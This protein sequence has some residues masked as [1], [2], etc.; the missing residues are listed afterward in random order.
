M[1]EKHES[2]SLEPDISPFFNLAANTCEGISEL[3]SSLQGYIEEVADDLVAASDEW[4]TSDNSDDSEGYGTDESSEPSNWDEPEGYNSDTLTTCAVDGWDATC[5]EDCD[6]TLP[7]PERIAPS[8]SSPLPT[9]PGPLKINGVTISGHPF[10]TAFF[11]E[12]RA[13]DIP[14]ATSHRLASFLMHVA[15]ESCFDFVQRNNPL[16]L[17]REIHKAPFDSWDPMTSGDQQELQMWGAH[18]QFRLS[19][20]RPYMAADV[21]EIPDLTPVRLIAVHSWAVENTRFIRR[22]IGLVALLKDDD[23]LCKIEQVLQVLYWRQQPSGDNA[24]A[25]SAEE[26]RMVDIALGLVP[27]PIKTPHQLLH[28][29]QGIVEKSCFDF[30]AAKRPEY[31]LKRSWAFNTWDDCLPKPIHGTGWDCPERV[32]LNMWQDMAWVFPELFSPT[33]YPRFI[34]LMHSMRCLRNQA[35]H[36]SHWGMKPVLTDACELTR[37][38]GDTVG[39]AQIEALAAEAQAIFGPL[40][41]YDP[42]GA[43]ILFRD[44]WSSLGAIDIWDYEDLWDCSHGFI[45]HLL[46]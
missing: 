33:D 23:R 18:L 15:E 11:E 32:E 9:S 46:R 22:V 4:S 37:L 35:A 29:V 2:S 20:Y 38:L 27:S 3:I 30:Y 7:V 10:L 45:L 26:N 19:S 36:R 5:K 41:R 40:F 6:V 12:Q 25:I 21:S 8:W 42:D 43:R 1:C 17:P 16:G 34:S 31:L 13:M 28:R 24:P 39:A 14:F 44:E